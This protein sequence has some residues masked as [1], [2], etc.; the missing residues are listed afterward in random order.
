[1]CNCR[2]RLPRFKTNVRVTKSITMCRNQ[3]KR[4]RFGVYSA[5]IRSAFGLANKYV[6]LTYKCGS[7]PPT[8]KYFPRPCLSP[9]SVACLDSG[10][11]PSAFSLRLNNSIKRGKPVARQVHWVLM[12][13]LQVPSHPLALRFAP[14]ALKV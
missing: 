5:K 3:M 6:R 12:H 10:F 2:K 1:M 9:F 7:A 11:A 13:L 14:S 4:C 8:L